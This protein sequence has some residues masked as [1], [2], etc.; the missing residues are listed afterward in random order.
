MAQHL[1]TVLATPPT[2][3][4]WHFTDIHVDPLYVINSSIHDNCNGAVTND[5]SAGLFG[6][7]TGNCATPWKLYRSALDFMTVEN[8]PVDFILFTGDYTQA[9][10]HSENLTD[11]VRDTILRTHIELKAK[12]PLTTKVYGSVGN[13]DSWPGDNFPYPCGPTCQPSYDVLAQLWDLDD[14]G[15]ATVADFGGFS[16]QAAP[17]LTIISP[18][19]MYW[20]NLNVH[21]KAGS[22]DGAYGFGFKQMDWLGSELDKAAARK[23]AVWL[24]GHVPGDMWL[25][26]HTT[27]YQQLIEKHSTMIKGQFYGHDHTDGIK[28]TRA[29]PTSNCTGKPTGVLWAAPSLTEGYPSENPGIRLMRY[30][31][32]AKDKYAFTHAETYSMDLEEANKKGRAEW[33]LEYDA[34]SAYNLTDLSP[35]SW[36]KWVQRTLSVN[37]SAFLNYLKL[38]RRGFNGPFSSSGTPCA[39]LNRTCF[40]K[41]ACYIMHLGVAATAECVRR[42]CHSIPPVQPFEYKVTMGGIKWCSG[43]GDYSVGNVFGKGNDGPHCPLIPKGW[44]MNETAQKCE[45]ICTPAAECVGFTLYPMN[46]SAGSGHGQETPKECCFRTGTVAS[47]PKAPGSH[48]R[49]YEKPPMKVVCGVP[50]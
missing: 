17:G 31:T 48:V 16:Q 47:K 45:A 7:A 6:N 41:E 3:R 28:L 34:K 11:G 8:P 13:H 18:N 46:A 14:A 10:L 49:C 15:R 4:V 50:S 27:K 22:K 42:T 38:R 20:T 19:T 25:E 35:S 37:E 33:R 9:G 39:G 1:A 43:G 30:D 23:D 5:T 24:L 32:K 36:E 29:C 26:E 40:A 12:L 44:S 21:V 2:G